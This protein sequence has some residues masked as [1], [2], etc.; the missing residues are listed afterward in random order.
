MGCQSPPEIATKPPNSS[1]KWECLSAAMRRARRPPMR[2]CGSMVSWLAA[3]A[4]PAS[5]LTSPSWLT[6]LHRYHRV[7]ACCVLL[8][9]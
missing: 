1:G 2:R 7:T 3:P 4:V 8:Q 6:H 9:H 5:I